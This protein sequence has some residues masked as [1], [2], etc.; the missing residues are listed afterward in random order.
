MIFNRTLADISLAKNIL[1]KLKSGEI[2]GYELT[3]EDIETLERG[4]LTKNTLNRIESKTQELKELFA[5]KGYF[6]GP[7]EVR[8]WTVFDTFTT[9][10]FAQILENVNAL[11]EVYYTFSGTPSTPSARYYY[12][13]INDLEKIL[14]D[15]GEMIEVVE[16]NALRCGEAFCGEET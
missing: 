8:D 3:E 7:L 5:G 9:F 6:V 15:L 1:D 14:F 16:S 11:R 4:T 10:D 2:A 13:D 12:T